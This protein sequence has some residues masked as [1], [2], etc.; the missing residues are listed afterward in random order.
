MR[1]ESI[2]KNYAEALLT[3][4]QN[5]KDPAGWGAMIA[6]VA[7]A[8]G[9]EPKLRLF[10]DSP[11]VSVTEK[12]EILSKA[13][14]DRL[15]RLLV[16][17]LQILVANRRQNL[18]P[19]ISSAYDDL[20]SAVENRVHADVTVARPMTPDEEKTW[21]AQMSKAVGKTVVPR[22]RIDPAIMGGIVIRYGDTIMD[23]SVRHRL[24]LLRQR[25]APR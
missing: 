4:A 20:L 11:R 7:A 16:R 12:N 9:R 8:I 13:F 23:G 1:D 6:D 24:S 14:Q 19:E 5:A 3:L 10:L 17:F 22:I 2:A 18:I 21:T 25:L 15:P